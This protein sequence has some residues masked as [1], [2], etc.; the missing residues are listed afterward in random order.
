MTNLSGQAWLSEPQTLKV[1]NA[2]SAHGK[3]P[4]FV[5][6]CVRDALL[7]RPIHDIDIATPEL[8]E[9]VVGLL[10]TAGIKAVPTGLEH[11][12][13][14]AVCEGKPFE[15]TTLRSDIETDGRHAKV[16]FTENWL[17]DAERRDFTFNAMSCDIK[18]EVYDP[19]DGI[20]DLKAGRV[21]FV[22]SPTERIKEDYLRLLRFFRFN[23]HFG[24]G[25]PD[26]D[27]LS[28]CRTLKSG[29]DGLSGER[30]AQEFLRLLE[31]PNPAKWVSLMKK[32]GVLA[33]VLPESQD[34]LLLEMLCA[35]ED[36]P[37]AIRRLAILL[38]A[39]KEIVIE[40]VKRLRLS[41]AQKKRLDLARRSV[42]TLI[43]TASKDTVRCFLF[44]YGV[45]AARDQIMIYW[46]EKG[47]SGIGPNEQNLLSLIDVWEIKPA[48]FP[49]K[50][51]DLMKGGLSA[52]PE[53]GLALQAVQ[54]WWCE[55]GCHAN[56]EK[57]LEQFF[58][59]QSQSG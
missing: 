7:H 8:P 3:Q 36:K 23:A 1:M 24:K 29:L 34:S 44:Q 33:H 52:G 13:I 35:F 30:I 22:G 57:C 58:L 50:G 5:G 4:R 14:T 27:A 45:V 51:R 32:E 28:A 31:A 55:T 21:R 10:E 40:C 12:T 56:K 16:T 11:G 9:T 15:I 26:T 42:G 39:K 59:L 6:G 25:L 19:F 46:A 43:P 38:P 18:G 37:D 49:L 54:S 20:S 47:F 41:N 17:V 53:L 2:L 48:V